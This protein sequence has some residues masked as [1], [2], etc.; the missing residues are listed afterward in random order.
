MKET[1]ERTFARVIL[2]AT[3]AMSPRKV[4]AVLSRTERATSSQVIRSIR[5]M[6][7]VRYII[8]MKEIRRNTLTKRERY[9]RLFKLTDVNSFHLL[10]L[11][12]V[13]LFL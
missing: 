6:R 12:Y 8:I 3:D 1:F 10:F 4:F 11:T 9:C 5:A 7:L 13:L 2:D